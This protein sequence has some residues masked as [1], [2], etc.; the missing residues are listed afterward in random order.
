MNTL[1][2]S[3]LFRILFVMSGLA[4][5]L[6]APY[7]ANAGE[8]YK[9]VDARGHITYS[10]QPSADA[11]QVRLAPVPKSSSAER[12]RIAKQMQSLT[13]AEVQRAERASAEKNAQVEKEADE[14]RR[15]KLCKQAR[16]RYFTFKEARRPYRRDDQG[17]RVYYSSADID[18]E[19]AA[20]EKDVNRLCAAQ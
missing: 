15:Q 20:T 8:I 3:A 6:T 11:K 14:Q 10:D 1:A 2:H 4:I 19:R 16:D 17:N 13:E 18:A 7:A 5:A 12:E 9:T